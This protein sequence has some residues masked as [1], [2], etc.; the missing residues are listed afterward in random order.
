MTTPD[1]PEW[2]IITLKDLQPRAAVRRFKNSIKEHWNHSCAYCGKSHDERGNPLSMSLDH[3]LP[4]MQGGKNHRA[5][6]ASCCIKCNQDK[7][8]Q[9]YLDWWKATD[10]YCEER[11]AKLKAWMQP[12]T[13]NW[14]IGEA[15]NGS[16]DIGTT[17]SVEASRDGG[18]PSLKGIDR[19]CHSGLLG[20]TL[21]AEA[22]VH[23][24]QQGGWA[25]LQVGRA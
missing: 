6:L 4:R 25:E 19:R 22:G 5:N 23:G 2:Y 13:C 15:L 7:G 17:V 16:A 12:T 11:H 3:I 9:A 20:A 21:Q 18:E 24:I 1:S 8:S 14:T 10:H